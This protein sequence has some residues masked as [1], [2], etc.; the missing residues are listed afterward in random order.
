MLYFGHMPL[1]F[2]SP[3]GGVGNQ[4]HKLWLAVPCFNFFFHFQFSSQTVLLTSLVEIELA[5]QRTWI[6]LNIC[7]QSC[8]KTWVI[9]WEMKTKRIKGC[10]TVCF[11]GCLWRTWAL[12]MF[13]VGFLENIAGAVWL[14]AWSACFPQKKSNFLLSS[15]MA[16]FSKMKVLEL[17][18][19]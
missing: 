19:G 15:Q 10:K 4:V 11:C 2:T 14:A 13:S 18:R 7:E 3:V 5:L 8:Y 6:Q 16:E 1:L 9:V 17:C 12:Y